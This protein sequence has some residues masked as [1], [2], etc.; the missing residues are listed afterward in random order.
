[1]ELEVRSNMTEEEME[2]DKTQT[3]DTRGISVDDQK[4]RTKSC[5]LS[6]ETLSV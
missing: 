2:H 1:M 3:V 5:E 4:I 6:L